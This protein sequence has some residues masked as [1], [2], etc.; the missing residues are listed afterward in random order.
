MEQY[1]KQQVTLSL[2]L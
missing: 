1:R 2:N